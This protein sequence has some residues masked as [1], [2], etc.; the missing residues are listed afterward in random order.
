MNNKNTYASLHRIMP[1]SVITVVGGGKVMSV[2]TKVTTIT[3]VSLVAKVVIVK[4]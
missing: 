2:V 4:L 1:R 3:L